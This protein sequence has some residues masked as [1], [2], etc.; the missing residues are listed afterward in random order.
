MWIL[1]TW[2]NN[3]EVLLMARKEVR[4][5]SLKWESDP[6][7]TKQG[8]K[9]WVE[10]N[11]WLTTFTFPSKGLLNSV[12]VEFQIRTVFKTAIALVIP[13]YKRIFGPLNKNPLTQQK[14][15]EIN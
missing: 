3:K 2:D 6:L 14:R 1:G 7:F 12:R 4:L 10:L 13:I 15:C 9:K 11:E 8:Y 5:T